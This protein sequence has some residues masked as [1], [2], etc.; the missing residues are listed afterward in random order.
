VKRAINGFNS[1]VTFLEGNDNTQHL[2]KFNDMRR[3]LDGVRDEDFYA[4]LP[5]LKE[6]AKYE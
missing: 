1:T 3:L 5:E 6:L 2:A 4:T